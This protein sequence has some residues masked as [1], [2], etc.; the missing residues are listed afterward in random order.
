MSTSAGQVSISKAIDDGSGMDYDLDGSF[1][2]FGPEAFDQIKG[3]FDLNIYRGR[4]ETWAFKDIKFLVYDDSDE[5]Q[6]PRE[7]LSTAAGDY[8]SD[9]E[10]SKL[11]YAMKLS[12][13]NADTGHEQLDAESSYGCK[14]GLKRMATEASPSKAPKQRYLGKQPEK[15]EEKQSPCEVCS[16]LPEF[17][18]DRKPR[19]LRLLRF[20]DVFNPCIH[21]VSLSYCWP[22]RPKDS[23]GK[24][25]PVK[26]T[27]EI[28]DL[29][30]K[31]RRNRA[32]DEVLDRAVDFAQTCGLRMIWIDQ[33]C[34]P[35]TDED[36]R[37]IGLQAMD[38][39]YNRAIITAGLHSTVMTSLSQIAAIETLLEVF[40]PATRVSLH[41]VFLTAVI[42]P[43]LDFLNSV[44]KEKWYQRA[45][46]AQESISAS[47]KL[48]LVFPLGFGVSLTGPKEQKHRFIGSLRSPS[49][50]LDNSSRQLPATQWSVYESDFKSLV[51]GIDRLYH[52]VL[53]RSIDD[54]PV[55]LTLKPYAVTILKAVAALR[56]ATPKTS[57]VPHM[58]GGASYGHRRKIS[59]AGAFTI[60]RT[61]LCSRP[62]D[63]IAIM[64][65]MCGYDIRLDTR[66]VK[67][68]GGSLRIAL[69]ALAT[70]N[71]DLSLFV[72][73]LYSSF[74]DHES[75][76]EMPLPSATAPGTTL[77][78]PFNANTHLIR[79]DFADN[80]GLI[81][82]KPTAHL[83]SHD[84]RRPG[85]NFPSYIWKVED[86]MDLTILK[87][88]WA[89]SWQCLKISQNDE[90]SMEEPAVQIS[91]G[92]NPDGEEVSNDACLSPNIVQT[93]SETQSTLARIIFGILRYLYDL[94]LAEN[95]MAAGVANSIW[96]SIRDGDFHN[97]PLP[98]KVGPD[99]FEHPLVAITP[100]DALQ[101]DP[102]PDGRSYN[103]LW[104]VERIMTHGTLWVG[105]YTHVDM[106]MDTRTRPT[107]KELQTSDEE[108]S[109]RNRLRNS[110]MHRQLSFGMMASLMNCISQDY[111]KNGESSSNDRLPPGM[112]RNQI[113]NLAYILVAD[114]WSHETEINRAQKLVSV[115]DVDK[116]C[117]V[118]TAYDADWELLPRPGLRSLST[119]WVVEQIVEEELDWEHNSKG[120]DKGPTGQANI[121]VGSRVVEGNKGTHL[122][123]VIDKV[124]G[125]WEI[126]EPPEKAH[127]FV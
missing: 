46:I 10:D 92:T 89:E 100:F 80:G 125:L 35:Q 103:Q 40:R 68:R 14:P 123:R 122:Y 70:M 22:S 2:P 119:C 58:I 107:S 55:L 26:G 102:S 7:P 37:E 15:S 99:L 105:R 21:Y 98:D 94:S 83:R 31:V 126:M 112:M 3:L 88:Q 118:A 66:A 127:Y 30:G 77:L 120:K 57:F 1:P 90:G 86:E 76:D 51:E 84:V 11:R 9:D 91:S 28:R 50:S 17:P 71:G 115:F 61:R 85:L 75:K 19:K 38:I 27:Y 113:T 97:P 96:H 93:K 72:P 63:R 78:Q 54:S 48:F 25:V 34:L 44:T 109:R 45:W 59:A 60:F 18:H 5:V 79:Y 49:H 42:P 56:P 81:R 43:V 24:Y 82:F 33:E 13:E 101:L 104:F 4:C 74:P 73:E 8:D 29:D 52:G 121:D 114:P 108:A 62:H 110:I 124:K 36:D 23:K 64:A 67:A 117:L 106:P 41:G 16:L 20:R 65:N 87:Y 69:L 53:D 47:G 39:V 95:A 116:S 12:L 111:D 6:Q 32:L